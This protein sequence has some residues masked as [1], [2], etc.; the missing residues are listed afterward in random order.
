MVPGL[1]GIGLSC[2]KIIPYRR[3]V[4]RG[5]HSVWLKRFGMSRKFQ[6]PRP[7][8]KVPGGKQKPGAWRASCVRL[9]CDGEEGRLLRQAARLAGQRERSLL[10]SSEAV[11]SDQ[12]FFKLGLNKIKHSKIMCSKQQR[13]AR[14]LSAIADELLRKP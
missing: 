3:R 5:V 2:A 9:F 12:R 13:R 7:L 4:R 8:S 6:R 1:S 11:F 14:T 10:K